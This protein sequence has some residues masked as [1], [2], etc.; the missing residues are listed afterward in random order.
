MRYPKARWIGSPNV[1]GA[2]GPV[3]MFVV[4]VMQGTLSS[5]DNW[6]QNPNAQ[7]SAHFG[8]GKA[9]EVH[10]YVDTSRVAWSNCNYNGCAI[11]I[12]H[13]GLSG[14]RLTAPQLTASVALLE[15]LHRLY[16]AVPLWRRHAVRSGVVGHGQLGYL[17]CDHPF[18]PGD[19]IL[20]QF[21]EVLD[22]L[23]VP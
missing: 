18:C 21:D 10:Q 7:V 5:C 11:S 1:G 22:V 3:A 20:A 17:G 2:M 15:W 19:P 8:V 9:G 14:E 12:E 6:F 16:P 13:E 4:H 23:R